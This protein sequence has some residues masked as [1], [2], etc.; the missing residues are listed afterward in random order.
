MHCQISQLFY[1]EPVF[2][3]NRGTFFNIG[4][5]NETWFEESMSQYKVEIIAIRI[6]ISKC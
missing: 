5:S 6:P 3:F 4:Y 1:F 2:E